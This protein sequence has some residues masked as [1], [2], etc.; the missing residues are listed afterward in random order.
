MCIVRRRRNR[1]SAVHFA[2]HLRPFSSLFACHRASPCSCPCPTNPNREFLMSGTSHGMTTNDIP[3]A[4][5]PQMV[6]TE[7]CSGMPLLDS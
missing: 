7:A 2:A 4:G 5:F 3:E 6:R 1:W